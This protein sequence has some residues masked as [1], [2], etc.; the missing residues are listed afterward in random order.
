MLITNKEE[1]LRSSDRRRTQGETEREREGDKIQRL[2]S[3]LALSLR[4]ISRMLC[5]LKIWS[6]P[7]KKNSRRRCADVLTPPKTGRRIWGQPKNPPFTDFPPHFLT[8]HLYGSYLCEPLLVRPNLLLCSCHAS[9]A[10][11]KSPTMIPTEGPTSPTPIVVD[12]FCFE[13]ILHCLE[14]W[15]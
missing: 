2:F 7:K 5:E 15:R 4:P 8:N 10:P 6:G 3:A 1:V 12:A 14:V 11:S 13:G 9:V